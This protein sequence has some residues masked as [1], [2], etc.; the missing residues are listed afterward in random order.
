MSE[1]VQTKQKNTVA[2]VWMICS[3][4]GLVLLFSVIWTWLGILLLWLW[5]IL[6]IIGLFYKPRGKARVAIIIPLIVIILTI[7]VACYVWKSVKTPAKEFWNWA[8][9]QLNEE[10]LNEID[11]DRFELIAREEFNNLIKSK[12][13]EE[14][15]AMYET[16]TWS[17]AIEKWSYVFFDMLKEWIT[18]SL[19]A[20]NNTEILDIDENDIDEDIDDSD[21]EISSETIEIFEDDE[22]DNI[23]EI[24]NILE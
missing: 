18:N 14:L 23:E 12:D 19:D 13:N 9:E 15:K 11:E 3:I 21:E 5:L 2:L 8:Q 24:L 1:D 10:T 4:V 6:W 16:S 17:N 7:A 22:Q 20:Y